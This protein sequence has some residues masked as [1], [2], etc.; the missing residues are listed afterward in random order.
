M[1]DAGGWRSSCGRPSPL[2]NVVLASVGF[3]QLL[4]LV[5][6]SGPASTF[7]LAVADVTGGDS[8]GDPDAEN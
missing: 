8:E 1:I 2:L 7:I 3:L 4:M 5:L 6:L